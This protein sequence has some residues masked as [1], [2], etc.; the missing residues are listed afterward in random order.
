VRLVQP[1]V[2]HHPGVTLGGLHHVV[3]DHV[4]FARGLGVAL[5]HESLDRVDGVV[6]VDQ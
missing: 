2:D 4:G 5:A 1:V 3:V 6:R